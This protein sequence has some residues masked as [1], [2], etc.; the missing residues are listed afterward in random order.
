MALDQH[1]TARLEL[2]DR[3]ERIEAL[4]RALAAEMA[5]QGT[6]ATQPP[7]ATPPAAAPA[8]PP[9]VP[10]A[11]PVPTDTSAAPGWQG[12]QSW[13]PAIFAGVLALALAAWLVRRRRPQ[14]SDGLDIESLDTETPGDTLAPDPD[15]PPPAQGRGS[16]DF[17]PIEWDGSSPAEL[18][19]SI[20]PITIEEA[21]L[22][23]EHESA[24]ELA[25]I[26]MSF[27]RIQGAAETL[28]EF[29]RSNP[30]QAVAP[31]LKLLEVYR[32]ADMR[33]DF[34]VITRQLNKTFNVKIV[35]WDDFD[36]ARQTTETVEQ[37]PHIVKM[38][39]DTWMSADCQAYIQ[40]L[41]RDNRD[42]A[43]QGF[44]IAVVDD[45]LMLM[46]VL[47][48]QLGPYTG[49]VDIPPPAAVVPE[50]PAP[51]EAEAAP[52][53]E[54]PIDFSAPLDT[55]TAEPIF[56][57]DDTDIPPSLSE[58]TL[59]DLDFHLESGDT[60]PPEDMAEPEADTPAPTHTPPT[61]PAGL[62]GDGDDDGFT[63]TEL[64]GGFNRK[65]DN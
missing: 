55:D 51:A 22:S 21:D 32:A 48:D 60:P 9:P 57:F 29:I 11:A 33:E 6:G 64:L 36:T 47:E 58:T 25:D 31:W 52:P 27:G 61:K 20:A 49:S 12:L 53:E 45:L 23:A 28:A 4:Q 37:M 59:P 10:A 2:T 43:R 38:L 1:I 34:E 5:Q 18:H 41:L 30:K 40:R 26:M 62:D 35:D 24:V 42:G 19:E 39:T 7:A 13:L 17:S 15:G 14:A 3:I 46:A 54:P 44:P 16:F 65:R 8:S 56:D 63:A 50:R